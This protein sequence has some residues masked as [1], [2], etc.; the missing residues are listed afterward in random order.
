[1][2]MGY[3]TLVV[4]S[5][6]VVVYVLLTLYQLNKL[7][8]K[9]VR[10]NIPTQEI[11]GDMLDALVAQDTYEKRYLILR[12]KNIRSLFWGRAE[13]FKKLLTR[14]EK[15]P[16]TASLQLNVIHKLHTQY[17]DL[18]MREVDLVK[19]GDVAAARAISDTE[20]RSQFEQLSRVLRAMSDEA[21]LSQDATMNRISELGSSAVGTTVM[22]CLVIILLGTLAGIVA[23]RQIVTSIHKLR[24]ATIQISEGNF[25][26]DPGIQSQD[27]IGDLANAFIAMGKRLK[28]LEEMY[29][30]ASPLTR[31]PGGVAVEN[32]MN[33]R[34][35]TGQQTAFCVLDMD[36]FKVFNDYYGYAR[37]N[38]VIKEVAKI[39]DVSVKTKGSADDFVGHIDG[40]DFVIITRPTHMREVCSE[41]VRLFDERIPQ[42][43]D[44]KD[45]ANGYIFGKSRQGQEMQFPIMTLSIA[46]VTNEKRTFANT[47]EAS[48]VAAELKDYAK[49]IPT[50]VF[51][52][53]QRRFA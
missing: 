26:Y 53:D 41:V 29:L 6:V 25:H 14:L 49:T 32:V 36:N 17:N 27:E 28:K 15:L 3:M 31:L 8:N 16:D 5:I 4:L 47:L 7:N 44:Q 13:E 48:T 34:L 39:L 50:S 24:V 22:L 45:L 33:K 12:G 43:Y 42:F 51:V 18:F 37:G 21:Q 46:V 38:E 1:M 35:E 30:D 52:V 40:D 9:V 19:A 2:L 23:T 11:A 20:L 10:V